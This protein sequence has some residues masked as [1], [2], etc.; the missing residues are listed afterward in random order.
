MAP[1]RALPAG[2]PPPVA[3]GELLR[4]DREA[5]R[6]AQRRFDRPLVLEAGAG[7]GKTTTLV[8]RL[9]AWCL[10]EG[11]ETAERRLAARA[12]GRGGATESAVAAQVLGGVVAI[13]FTEAAAAEMAS[14][15]TRELG[16]LARGGELPPWLDGE[17]LPRPPA[18]EQRARA[19][20]G[21]L[22]HLAVR[23]IHAF[24]FRLLASHPLEAGVHPDLT[25]DADGRRLERIVAETVERALRRG[26]GTPGEPHLLALAAAGHGPQE[27]AEALEALAAAGLPAAALDEDPFTAEPWRALLGRLA[28]ACHSLHAL[29][30]P[31]LSAAARLKNACG[32]ER[33]LAGLLA[34]LGEAGA[35]PA[36]AAPAAGPSPAAPPAPTEVAA[37]VAAAFPANLV[38]HLREWRK[39]KLGRG[40]EALLG[41]VRGELARHAGTLCRLLEHV[42]CLDPAR[43]GHARQALAPLLA[44]VEEELRRRGVATFNALLGGAAALL[45]EHPQVRTRLR[46]GIDQLLVDEFQDTDRVQCEILRWLAL[47]PPADERPGLFLVGDPKQSIYGWRSADL[48]AY[49]DFVEEVCA[50]GGEVMPLVEN[51]RSAPP[52]LAEVTRV[53][54]PVMRRRR[55]LQPRFEPLVACER[56]ASD[57]GFTHGGRRPV[58]HWVSS[59]P[60]FRPGADPAQTS[61]RRPAADAAELEAAAIAADL[62]VLHDTLGVAWQEMALLLRSTGDLDVYLEALRRASVPF[63]VGRDKNYYRRREVIEAAALVRAV[64]DPGDHLAL[65]TTLRSAVVGVPDAALIPLW[66]RELPRRMTELLAPRQEPLAA[67]R[68]VIEEA[69]AEVPA[70]VPGLARVRGWEINLL[71]AVEQLAALRESFMSEPADLFCERLRRL[72]LVEATAAARHLGA[73]RLANLDRFFRELLAA[74]ETG[75]GDGA[76]LLRTLRGDVA[77]AREAEEGRPA[78]DTEDAVRVL[79]IHGAK[80]LDFAHVYLPQLHKAAGGERAANTAAR[81]GGLGPSGPARAP[82]SPSWE[83]CLFGAATPGY[84]LVEA[85]R[86]EVEAAERV[87]TLYVGMTRAKDRLVLLGA[88][89]ERP[90]P[91]PPELARTHLHLLASRTGLPDLGAL[92]QAWEQGPE[93]ARGTGLT[94]APASGPEPPSGTAPEPG[95]EPGSAIDA[96]GTLWTLL[97]CRPDRGWPGGGDRPDASAAGSLHP[98]FLATLQAASASSALLARHRAAARARMARPLAGPASAEAHAL[99][100]E[101]RAEDRLRGGTPAGGRRRELAAAAGREA[102]MAAGAAFHRALETWDLDAETGEETARQRALL[103]A[104]LAPLAPFAGGAERA[105][106]LRRALSLLDRFVAGGLLDRLRSLR[107]HLLARELPILLPP[108][109]PAAA[110]DLAP[111][112]D[113]KSPAGLESPESPESRESPE[114]SGAAGGVE[115][116]PHPLEFVSGTIDLLYRDPATR[117]LAVADY[118]TDEVEDAEDLVRRAA[119]Y[120]SQGAA[121]TR[122]VQEALGLPEPPRF[123]LWFIRA[124][125]IVTPAGVGGAD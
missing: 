16:V 39:P 42:G 87:R 4:Q 33:G 93:A 53:I 23:T 123:E 120:A 116:P 2:G 79:T 7:T 1:D 58:E 49:H 57:P 95:P 56:R 76:A 97:A 13:T 72:F 117:A 41:E 107:G 28:A 113:S 68:Q 69:A 65:L 29:L 35:A 18:R 89:P 81:P 37:W 34:R 50:A 86:E 20:L 31:R 94:L 43:L 44:A 67:L 22:D 82:A 106:A 38:D 46:R 63:L 54:E 110:A 11:W 8:A 111:A 14:R 48:R 10:G 3:D 59:P 64:L 9:L 47:A 92:W 85:E 6:A 122:A 83:Y 55:G 71:A 102:A 77:S 66:G 124:G 112:A 60:P 118:K 125:R 62:R 96:D 45:A 100:R 19:L 75:G 70:G 119:A 121:Y 5:R 88:W 98:P 78:G 108:A 109:E 12:V 51:F 91:L 30:A 24:C 74:F 26:Y 15:T 17:A 80:G 90:A 36:P 114:S 99:L 27:V 52:V 104:Y 101:Q 103:P 40:E 115:Q 73:Y 32:V 84:D 61:A 21:T 105:A 25:V